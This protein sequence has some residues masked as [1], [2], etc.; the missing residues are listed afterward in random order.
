M[1]EIEHKTQEISNIQQ[2]TTAAKAVID[3]YFNN[4]FRGAAAYREVKGDNKNANR[5]FSQ[6]WRDPLNKNYIESKQ[7][8]IGRKA[9]IK[10]LNVVRELMNFAFFDGTEFINLTPAEIKEL[11]SELRRLIQSYEHKKHSYIDRNDCSHT[12][13]IIRIKFVDKLKAIEMINKHIGFYEIDNK[14]K[15]NKVTLQQFNIETLN[16]LY[17]ALNPNR[18]D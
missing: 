2:P 7:I 8:E 14:Q 18:I 17:Q 3:E 5:L 10:H 12:E 9:D 1:K 6:I 11:P 13:E 4:G 15:A 16:A